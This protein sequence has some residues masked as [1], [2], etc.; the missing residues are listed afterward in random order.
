MMIVQYTIS[1]P[2]YYTCEGMRDELIHIDEES[3]REKFEELLAKV[4][5]KA[6]RWNIKINEQQVA[7]RLKEYFE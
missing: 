6:D 3:I 2:V 5:A 4:K 7:D 1:V